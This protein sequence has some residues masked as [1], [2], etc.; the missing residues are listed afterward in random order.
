MPN[1]FS[2]PQH[3]RR[4]VLA[5]LV[6]APAL[7]LGPRAQPAA[8]LRATPAQTEGPFYPLELPADSDFDLFLGTA[9]SFYTDFRGDLV[10]AVILAGDDV[11]ATLRSALEAFLLQTYR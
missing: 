6:A 2:P 4:A 11:D 9:S 5:A 10:A 8:P 3:A 1:H 7:W